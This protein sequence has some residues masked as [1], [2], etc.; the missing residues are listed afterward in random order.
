MSKMSSACWT[1]ATPSP[2]SPATAR[3]CTARWTTPSCAR[4]RR[5]CSTCATSRN[6]ARPSS[7]PLRSRASSRRSSPPPS[8]RPGPLP[9]LKTFI[10]RISR[11]AVPAPPLQRRRAWSLWR[12]FSSARTATARIRRRLRRPMLI[13]KKVWKPWKTPLPALR[14]SSPNR[15]ATAPNY[16][17][18]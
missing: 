2:S 12:S 11:N 1:R 5:G 10:A 4:W 14:T 15:S 18:P 3:S 16:A 6:A 17:K 7:P 13:R 8:G 9:S